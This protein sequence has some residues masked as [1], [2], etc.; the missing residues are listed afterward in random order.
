MIHV[1]F[2]LLFKSLAVVPGAVERYIVD[3]EGGVTDAAAG[4]GAGLGV[5]AP[6]GDHGR[7]RAVPLE[8]A[9]RLARPRTAAR[10]QGPLHVQAEPI[11]GGAGHAALLAGVAEFVAEKRRSRFH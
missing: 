3:D 11:G 10:R 6:P 4:G 7:L 5:P 2:Q 8:D 9:P 1:L